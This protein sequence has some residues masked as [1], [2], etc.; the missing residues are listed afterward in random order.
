MKTTNKIEQV[1]LT[2]ATCSECFDIVY[3]LSNIEASICGCGKTLAIG[4]GDPPTIRWNTEQP[5]LINLESTVEIK[6]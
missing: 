1:T 4:G 3:S 6:K 5:P 2:T